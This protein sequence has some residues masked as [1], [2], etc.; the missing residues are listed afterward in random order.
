MSTPDNPEAAVADARR[1][2]IAI[3]GMACLFRGAPPR[4]ALGDR[5]REEGAPGGGGPRA[6]GADGTVP[7]QGILDGV[8]DFDADFFK[9]SPRDAALIDP[10]QRLF[11][12]CT[13]EA[14]ETAG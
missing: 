6:G 13:F 11:L 1:E 9:I 3:I 10:Q 2:G 14:L 8:D 5:R 12:A 7:P 4:A